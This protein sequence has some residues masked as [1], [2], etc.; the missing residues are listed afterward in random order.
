MARRLL[1]L[2]QLHVNG[3]DDV[4]AY[5]KTIRSWL[6]ANGGRPLGQRRAIADALRSPSC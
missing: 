4:Q 6:Q 3:G 5:A 2:Q 1:M